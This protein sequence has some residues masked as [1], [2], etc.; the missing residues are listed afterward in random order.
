M[1][2]CL[3]DI[4][5]GL[6]LWHGYHLLIP[7]QVT[8]QWVSCHLQFAGWV[9]VHRALYTTNRVLVK[10]IIGLKIKSP[11]YHRVTLLG[12]FKQKLFYS[13]FLLQIHFSSMT[14]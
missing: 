2:E 7:L 13:R 3:I 4:N 6:G 12:Y 8:L 1:N 14:E 11:L 9:I 10:Y 5:C